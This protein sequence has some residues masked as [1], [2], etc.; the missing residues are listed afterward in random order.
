VKE[1]ERVVINLSSKKTEEQWGDV[2]DVFYS[3]AVPTLFKWTSWSVLL[4][5]LA[6]IQAATSDPFLNGVVVMLTFGF[7]IHA[8]FVLSRIVVVWGED[9]SAERVFRKR[10]K[11][12]TI[13]LVLALYWSFLT[14]ANGTKE[15]I[16]QFQSL[17]QSASESKS[18]NDH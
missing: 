18:D 12:V 9:A 1:V 11:A 4:G 15:A 7:F 14:V 13:V 8:S 5:G 10:E 16:A 6:H 2:L 3:G 17:G